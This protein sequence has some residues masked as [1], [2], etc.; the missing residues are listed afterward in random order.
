MP[1]SFAVPCAMN[2]YAVTIRRMASARGRQ[3]SKN[4]TSMSEPP[5]VS[6][7]GSKRFQVFQHRRQELAYVRVDA[8]VPLELGAGDFRVHGVDE[9]MHG[10]VG[11]GAQ[12]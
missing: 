3:V 8:H 9:G 1:K 11:A 10:L 5:R 2:R 4:A 6:D 12:Q 7:S